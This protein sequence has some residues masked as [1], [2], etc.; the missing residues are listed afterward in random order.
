VTRDAAGTASA[1]MPEARRALLAERALLRARAAEVRTASAALV[2][3][4]VSALAH[5]EA[6]RQTLERTRAQWRAWHAALAVRGAASG[7]GDAG[8]RI[9]VGCEDVGVARPAPL[10]GV[11]D[12]EA[13]WFEPPD[14]VRE[15][16]R[17]GRHRGVLAPTL[18]ARCVAAG[19]DLDAATGRAAALGYGFPVRAPRDAAATGFSDVLLSVLAELEA[20]A[21]AH[22][23]RMPWLTDDEAMGHAL[24]AAIPV[25][26]AELPPEDLRM[27]LAHLQALARRLGAESAAGAAEGQIARFR[28]RLRGA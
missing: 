5:G 4:W 6:A 23:A 3:I 13:I 1:P 25:L 18:C 10:D 27:V 19:T 8:L 2:P 15:Q 21:V 7:V 26:A 9:C 22:G 11:M 12:V 17:A 20:S 28:P 24:D 14:A 16:L